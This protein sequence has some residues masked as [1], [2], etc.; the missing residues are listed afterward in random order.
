MA[1]KWAGWL[2][3]PC[4]LAGPPMLHGGGEN[5]EWPKNGLVG[6]IILAAWGVPDASEGTKLAV[7]DKWATW[8]HNPYRLGGLQ[9]ST[10]GEKIS[11]GQQMGH[12]AT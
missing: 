7:A 9:R 8:L 2:H 11:S 5:K 4:R 1:Q 3:K 6:Y 10:A 12:V